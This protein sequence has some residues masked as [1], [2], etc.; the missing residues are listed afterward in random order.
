MNMR[1]I[2]FYICFLGISLAVCFS[3]PALSVP[4]RFSP[5]ANR[6][7]DGG[8]PPGGWVEARSLQNGD[9]VFFADG[10]TGIVTGKTISPARVGEKT[11]PTYNF[12][13]ADYH[14]YFVGESGLF[15][16]NAG[17][18][19][20]PAPR[21]RAVYKKMYDDAPEA[22]V[23]GGV[24]HCKTGDIKIARLQKVPPGA[25]EFPSHRTIVMHVEQGMFRFAADDHLGFVFMKDTPGKPP[26]FMNISALN[27]IWTGSPRLPEELARMIQ[28]M[29][30]K[31]LQ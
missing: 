12:T 15:V 17:N 19:C 1:R 29:L 20:W 26:H 4:E 23:F 6:E 30:N 11:E 24:Y 27:E 8:G 16:H 13:V 28:E 7:G 2:A 10:P 9:T 3:A 14:T 18:P 22:T 25:G 31:H 21:W 5:A